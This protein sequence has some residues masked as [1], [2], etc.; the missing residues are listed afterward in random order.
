VIGREQ[1]TEA[2][3]SK[4]LNKGELLIILAAHFAGE[5]FDVGELELTK[6]DEDGVV[7]DGLREVEF[8]DDKSDAFKKAYA[9]DRVVEALRLLGAATISEI[10]PA[11]RMGPWEVNE[12]ISALAASGCVAAVAPAREDGNTVSKWM[13]TASEGFDAFVQEERKRVQGQVAK[14]KHSVLENMPK[15]YEPF[16]DR[17]CLVDAICE[18]L[19]SVEQEEEIRRDAKAIFYAMEGDQLYHAN[20][21]W[22]LSR[23]EADAKNLE[24]LCSALREVLP[25]ERLKLEQIQAL[26]PEPVEPG[27]LRHALHRLK[28]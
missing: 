28:A 23:T 26:L 18:G 15:Y 7:L 27:L 4:M 16:A 12:V 25:E 1:E 9:T 2:M 21:G 17:R 11:A 3:G 5:G 20:H 10:Y 24:M 22:R 14:W 13:L 19:S 6:L 8:D